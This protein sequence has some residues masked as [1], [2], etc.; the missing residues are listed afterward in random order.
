M[1]ITP[2]DIQQQRFRIRMRGYDPKEVDTFL[3]LLANELAES[4]REVNALRDELRLR[5]QEL[6]GY[7]ERERAIQETLHTAQKLREQIQESARKEAQLIVQ[8]AE[9][10]AEKLLTAGHLRLSKVLE[11]LTTLKGQRVQLEEAIRAVA[12]RHLRL[13]EVEREERPPEAEDPEDRLRLV[14]KGAPAPAAAPVPAPAAAPAH[15]P[16]AA[17]KPSPG[18]A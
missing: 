10:E 15:V 3:E 7:R 9:Q 6:A 1:K 5:E 17:S 12:Q 14:R 8:Q 13:L 18:G 2:L 4:A 16:A 11:E